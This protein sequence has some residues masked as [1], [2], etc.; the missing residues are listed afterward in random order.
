MNVS[1]VVCEG[2]KK[3]HGEGVYFELGPEHLRIYNGLYQLNKE[4]LYDL[5][6]GISQNLDDFRS[7]YSSPNFTQTFGEIRGEKNKVL[8]KEFKPFGEKEPLLYN[9][10]FYYFSALPP[11]TILED[12]LDQIIADTY[13]TARPLEKF[14]SQ[15]VKR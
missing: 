8:P 15:F 5:R 7:I 12:K 2:G 3:N 13:A 14:L 4:E 11:E 1:A 6:E 10:Q 9:K